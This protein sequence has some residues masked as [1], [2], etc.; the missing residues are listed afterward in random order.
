MCLATIYS[1]R[2]ITQMCKEARDNLK[3]GIGYKTF[4]KINNKLIP[5]VYGNNIYKINH[6]YKDKSKIEIPCSYSE[7]CYLSGYHIFLTIKAAKNYSIPRLTFVRK[8]HFKN[9]KAVGNQSFFGPPK[10]TVIAKQMKI[11]PAK[12]F[13]IE[14]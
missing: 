6:W 1:K 5:E 12:E 8:V 9:K 14:I 2:Q 10:H 3:K 7:R 4:R 13:S 11:L